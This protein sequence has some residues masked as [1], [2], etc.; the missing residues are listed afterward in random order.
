VAFFYSALALLLALDRLPPPPVS[1]TW[2]IDS[3]FAWLKGAPHWRNASFAAVG[4]STTWR[5]LDFSVA[6]EAIASQGIVN[7]AP[8][9]LTIN[10]TRYLTE[11]L[12]ERAPAT[13]TV[14]TVVTLRD[15]E[16]CSR[17][18]TAFFDPKVADDYLEGRSYPW[19]LY[20]RNFRFKDILFHALY[21]GERRSQMQY[22]RFGS[23]PL[24]RQNAELGHAFT[25]EAACYAELGQLATMLRAR[26]V[27]FIVVTFPV[28]QSWAHHYDATGHARASFRTGVEKALA[29]TGAILVDGMADWEVPDSAFTDPV[30]LQWPQTAAFTR[31]VLTAASHAGARLP[32]LDQN[33]AVQSNRGVALTRAGPAVAP[34]SAPMTPNLRK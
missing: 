31:F 27:Q 20:F 16:G 6:P 21:A 28:M 2:C 34:P 10:Q 3:R 18:P 1:G 17:N 7:A 14:L 26:G 19:W 15:L 29:S 5:N 25:P 23:G 24:T 12:L 8:C 33:Y 22:D 30:H 13:K 11:Y 4:S 9:F 32:P